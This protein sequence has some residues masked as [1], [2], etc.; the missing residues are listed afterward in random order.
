[1]LIDNLIITPASPADLDEALALI[2]RAGLPAAGVSGHF[3]SFLVARRGSQLVGTAGLELYGDATLLRSIAVADEAQGRGIGIALTQHAL[4]RAQNAGARM[5]YLLTTSAADFFAR[6]FQFASLPREAVSS[7]LRSSAELQ[8]ECP[9]TAVTMVRSLAEGSAL[10]LQDRVRLALAGRLRLVELH[11]DRTPAAVLLLLYEKDSVP[12]MLFTRRSMQV[13]DHKGEVSFPGGAFH[14]G[15]DASL[16]GTALRESHE[17]VGVP[18]DNVEILGHLDDLLPRSPYIMTPY[19]GILRG[20]Q[21]FEPSAAEVAEVL[22]IP[23][24]H[25]HDPANH[26]DG[27]IDPREYAGRQITGDYL[28]YRDAVVWGA[29]YRVLRQFL[30]LFPGTS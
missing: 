14:H 1:M 28:E 17:E 10:A 9:D 2:Q 27:R 4:D 21:T 13:E 23:L 5:A 3:S 25:L 8:G 29:T 6:K 18:P 22:E 12:H 30:E 11:P 15:V 7:R 19:V 20:P 26:R 16:L 24:A